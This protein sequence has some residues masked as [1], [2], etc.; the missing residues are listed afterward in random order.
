MADILSSIQPCFLVHIHILYALLMPWK[1]LSTNHNSR[2]FALGHTIRSQLSKL[3][4]NNTTE[5]DRK[6]TKRLCL[7]LKKHGAK[8]VCEVK[9]NMTEPLIKSIYLVISTVAQLWLMHDF[10]EFNKCEWMFE[11]IQYACSYVFNHIFLR[12]ETSFNIFFC[13]FNNF[14]VLMR[15]KLKKVYT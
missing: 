2:T 11:C 4:W 13:D 15:A 6:Y 12:V 14:F 7:K 3:C 5:I 10:I 9:K 8:I 1:N